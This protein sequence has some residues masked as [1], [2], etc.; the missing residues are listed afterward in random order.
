M[1]H[2]LTLLT[3]VDGF[4]KSRS[5]VF[6]KKTNHT[7][8]YYAFY[9]YFVEYLSTFDTYIYIFNNFHLNNLYLVSTSTI[10]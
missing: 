5:V 6:E 8:G 2:I 3:P 10:N 1:I 7:S 9:T 4:F